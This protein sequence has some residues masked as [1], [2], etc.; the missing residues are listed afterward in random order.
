[1]GYGVRRARAGKLST[2]CCSC[3]CSCWCSCWCSCSCSLLLLLPASAPI[4]RH[5][6]GQQSQQQQQ[7]RGSI[8]LPLPL[9]PPE[10]RYC[11]TCPG[12]Q[13]T[14]SGNPRSIRYPLP[15]PLPGPPPP[16]PRPAPGGKGLQGPVLHNRMT[17]NKFEIEKK[18]SL[19]GYGSG[20]NHISPPSWGPG[21]LDPRN[22]GV[23]ILFLHFFFWWVTLTLFSP[24]ACWS[25]M[26]TV[27]YI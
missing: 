27:T 11:R 23:G 26:Q 14:A 8:P 20:A 13:S 24:G 21:S 12:V 4:L 18:I 19:P 3:S 15:L 22:R 6:H 7:P 1:M 5:I 9:P 16:P 25:C 10:V 17:N 2:W